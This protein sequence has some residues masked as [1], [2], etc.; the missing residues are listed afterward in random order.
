MLID[1]S[2]ASGQVRLGL[3][4]RPTAGRAVLIDPQPDHALL[5]IQVR[6]AW[7][8][9]NFDGRLLTYPQYDWVD[10]GQDGLARAVT[11]GKT[12]FIRGNGKWSIEPNFDWLDRFSENYAVY[13]V[14]GGG[15]G[16]ID[17][18]GRP[19][20]EP[21]FNA[22]LR[23]TDGLAAVRFEGRCGYLDQ[24]MRWAIEPG[25]AG[26]RS[27][28]NSYAAVR[29]FPGDRRGKA[30]LIDKRGRVVFADPSGEVL[31]FGD[32]SDGMIRCETSKG[33]GYLDQRFRPVIQ[34]RFEDAREFVNGLAAVKA[35]GKWGY[36]DKT[37]RWQVQPTY[38]FADDFDELLAMVQL[39]GK[40]GYIG[41]T[42][43]VMIEPQFDR[44]EPFDRGLARV[45]IGESFGYIDTSGRVIWDPRWAEVGIVDTTAQESAQ[46]SVDPL[47]QA[48]RVLPPPPPR[49]AR[50][51][52][53][54]LEY[55][56]EPELPPLDEPRSPDVPG[57]NDQI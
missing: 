1:I 24:R 42:G 43:R 54:L 45:S 22:A 30:G 33:W 5:P 41:K 31:R 23:M 20:A 35:D 52:P 13:G 56:Y 49:E 8:L 4:D 40:F 6:H 37:G 32:L 39:E 17:R 14:E 57:S 46:R 19:I 47:A 53:Y 7:G 26:V 11:N 16:Y 28:N 2:S 29:F 51:A 27:F 9:M 36:I 38:D 10:I 18:R 44:A 21:R 12:G 25:F 34:P 48:N 15:F 50:P 3:L 55:L